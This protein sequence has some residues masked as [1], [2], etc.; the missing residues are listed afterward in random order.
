MEVSSLVEAILL[1]I[2]KEKCINKDSLIYP[3]LPKVC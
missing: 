2:I 1:I 3:S